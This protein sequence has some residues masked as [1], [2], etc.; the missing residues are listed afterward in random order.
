MPYAYDNGDGTY[1][2][3]MFYTT[4]ILLNLDD[5][6]GLSD[7]YKNASGS[8]TSEQKITFMKLFV[9][10]LTTVKQ[11]LTFLENYDAETAADLV[12]SDLYEV[13]EDG[14]VKKETYAEAEVAITSKLNEVFAEGDE[15]KLLDAFISLMEQ[16]NDD[17]GKLSHSG[18]LVSVGDMKNGWYEDFTATAIKM[19]FAKLLAGEEPVGYLVGDADEYGRINY[20]YSDYGVH[21]MFLTFAPMY[22]VAIDENGG[23]GAETELNIDGDTRYAEIEEKLLD[24]AKSAKYTDWQNEVTEEIVDK[25]STLNEKYYKTML[26]DIKG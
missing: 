4:H 7:Q 23:I 18:Y 1:T 11:K 22:N 10:Q 14:N 25:H 16:Y 15:E 24:S 3:N 2:I 8:Y 12:L 20:A 26:K 13:D 5:V 9:Q 19:Y 17:S 21:F 6:A